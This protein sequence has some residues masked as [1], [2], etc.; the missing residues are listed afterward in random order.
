MRHENENWDISGE[1]QT[2]FIHRHVSFLTFYP[3]WPCTTLFY[4]SS[5]KLQEIISY[6]LWI[7]DVIHY[8]IK[9]FSSI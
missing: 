7:S 1:N 5:P 4:M 8:S 6:I 2:G 9:K 3:H